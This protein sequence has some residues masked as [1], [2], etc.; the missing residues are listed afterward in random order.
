MIGVFWYAFPLYREKTL[1]LGRYIE[2]IFDLPIKKPPFELSELHILETQLDFELNYFFYGKDG[3][4]DLKRKFNDMEKLKQNNRK[5]PPKKKKPKIV[6]KKPP[7][8]K[9]DGIPLDDRPFIENT[10]R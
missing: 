9:W 6:K 7:K 3:I 2:N 10:K 8:N 4:R 5:L 1:K